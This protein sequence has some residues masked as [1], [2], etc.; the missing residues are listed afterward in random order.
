MGLHQRQTYCTPNMGTYTTSKNNITLLCVPHWAKDVNGLSTLFTQKASFWP[1]RPPPG[2]LPQTR[3][4]LPCHVAEH[5]RLDDDSNGSLADE[6]LRG[7]LVFVVQEDANGDRRR[8]KRRRATKTGLGRM[9]FYSLYWYGDRSMDHDFLSLSDVG[10]LR[11][12]CVGDVCVCVCVCGWV[13]GGMYRA[14]CVLWGWAFRSMAMSACPLVWC[15][16]L[17][18]RVVVAI[19]SHF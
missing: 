12:P 16:T 19:Q 3:H 6:S 18:H 14:P 9:V 1:P 4:V 5:R 11:A 10:A 17:L 15:S 2:V 13:G 8:T 7:H